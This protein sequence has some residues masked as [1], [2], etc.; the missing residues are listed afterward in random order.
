M[1]AVDLGVGM[2][3]EY[4]TVRPL[5]EVGADCIRNVKLSWGCQGC[6]TVELDGVS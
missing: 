3:R 2:G 5:Q 6:M 4:R 1:E